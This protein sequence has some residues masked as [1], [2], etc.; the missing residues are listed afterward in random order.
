[1]S[2]NSWFLIS[3]HR[4]I[5]IT[6]QVHACMYYI[7]RYYEWNC[8]YQHDP[9]AC[10]CVCLKYLSACISVCVSRCRYRKIYVYVH[11]F[12]CVDIHIYVQFLALSIDSWALISHSSWFLNIIFY[13]YKPWLFRE[14]TNSKPEEGKL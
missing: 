7:I 1:M 6:I 8:M 9:N 4:S 14:K 11:M 13:L 3:R 12:I 10:V 2:M 5:N